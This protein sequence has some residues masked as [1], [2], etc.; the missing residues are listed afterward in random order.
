VKRVDFQNHPETVG[1]VYYDDG[2]LKITSTHVSIGKKTLLIQSLQGVEWGVNDRFSL[3]NVLLALVGVVGICM[4]LSGIMN[5]MPVFGWT[6]LLGGVALMWATVGVNPG[7]FVIIKL[8]GFNNEGLNIK[9]EAYAKAISDCI[10]TAIS[11][12]HNPPNDGPVVYE[13]IFPSPVTLRN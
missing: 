2:F 7:C 6:F 12:H 5:K 3:G 9:K 4:G 10:L 8:A 11:D 1:H 13:P